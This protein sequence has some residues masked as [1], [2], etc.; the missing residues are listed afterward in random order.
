MPTYKATEE[1]FYSFHSEL[2][3]IVMDMVGD[4]IDKRTLDTMFEDLD[5]LQEEYHEKLRKIY[6]EDGETN[7]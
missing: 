4:L 5:S 3:A 1:L 2:E 7:E 6:R